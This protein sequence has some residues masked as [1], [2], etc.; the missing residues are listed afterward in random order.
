MCVC[1]CI[2]CEIAK[3]YAHI[4]IYT[5]QGLFR[6]I[7]EKC[8]FLQKYYFITPHL[9]INTCMYNIYL[10][11]YVTY[12]VKRITLFFAIFEFALL[13]YFFCQSHMI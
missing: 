12:L 1:T 11:N 8:M 4:Y 3:I 5:F 7:S 6:L 9:N 10:T 13:L 2:Y